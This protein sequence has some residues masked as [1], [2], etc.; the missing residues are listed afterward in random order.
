MRATLHCII[1]KLFVS[2]E[3]GQS[4][5]RNVEFF[6]SVFY[7]DY[8]IKLN[9]KHNDGDTSTGWLGNEPYSGSTPNNAQW[10]DMGGNQFQGKF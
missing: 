3:E 4:T 9:Y 8:E 10:Q 1:F 7:V 5:G 6:V 2:P